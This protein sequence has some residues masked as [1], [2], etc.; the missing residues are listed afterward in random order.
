M[1]PIAHLALLVVA[2]STPAFAQDPASEAKKTCETMYET[3]ATGD[4]AKLAITQKRPY[5]LA[6]HPSRASLSAAKPS[7]RATPQRSSGL[8]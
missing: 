2:L 1:R 5:T 3:A 6:P 7:R 8:S 4:A